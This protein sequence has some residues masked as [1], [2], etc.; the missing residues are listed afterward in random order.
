MKSAHAF[1]AIV[2]VV[3]AIVL[4]NEQYMKLSAALAVVM[5]VGFGGWAVLGTVWWLITLLFRRD[6]R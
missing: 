2:G 1:S 4:T 5:L 6:E 3:L